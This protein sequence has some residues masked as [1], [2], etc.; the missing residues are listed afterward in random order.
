MPG[1]AA[2][3]VA[4]TPNTITPFRRIIERFGYYDLYLIDHHTQ[5]ALYDVNKDRD[6]GTSLREGPYRESN[7]AK[8]VRQCLASDNADNV[9]FSDFEPYE[10]NR[11]E[12]TQWVATV[13]YDGGERLGILAAAIH[14]PTPSLEISRLAARL[15]KPS[16]G[17][18]PT[19]LP[20]LSCK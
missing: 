13:I 6:L 4:C 14:Y 8:V 11:G 12:P 9:V 7:L 2:T 16:T 15:K 10:A 17:S 20:S 3:T 19:T 5:R 18:E 1:T